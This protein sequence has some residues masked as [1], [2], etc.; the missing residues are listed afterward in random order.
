[1]HAAIIAPM[2]TLHFTL[3]AAALVVVALAFVLPTLLGKRARRGERSRR[4]VDAAL[5]E[6]E[7][8]ELQH[9][10]ALGELPADALPAER[11]ALRRR[12]LEAH[13]R[14][15]ATQSPRR[16]RIVALALAVAVPAI[17]AA[18]YFAVGKPE[19]LAPPSAGE[20]QGD[21]VT[22]LQS[23]LARQ[24][25][26]ARGWVLLA[27]AQADREEFQAA[28]AS[29]NKAVQLS[30]KV[31]KDPGVLCEYA[32]AL[33]MAQGR[34]LAG[35]PAELVAQA[36]AIDPKHPVG[37]EM[38]GSAAYEDGRYAEALVYW[39]ELLDQLPSSD[40]RRPELSAAIARA[41]RKAEVT[42]PS[43]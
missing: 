35:K 2:T 20:A 21:Y 32:D 39:K 17:A 42:L 29:F 11:E 43:R 3:I 8:D 37:L 31:A 12:L 23:H 16:A 1:M 30:G 25:R 27:R 14:V 4:D 10:V 7:L 34:K 19:A 13:P 26:D 28:A 36:L 9:D 5:F 22:R 41:E 6:Q 18:I 40:E 33:G 15:A 24:P 38:A